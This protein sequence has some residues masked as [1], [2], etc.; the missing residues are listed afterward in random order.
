VGETIRRRLGSGE[1]GWV[2]AERVQIPLVQ[3]FFDRY[4]AQSGM[5]KGL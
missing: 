2:D 5:G 1:P 4:S 3:R